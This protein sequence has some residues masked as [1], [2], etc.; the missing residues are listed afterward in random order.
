MI[1][2]ENVVQAPGLVKTVVGWESMR[3]EWF[4]LGAWWRY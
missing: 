4:E 1:S 2:S 3:S